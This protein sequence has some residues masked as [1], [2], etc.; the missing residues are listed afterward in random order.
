MAL[1]RE[2]MSKAT[3]LSDVY[4]LLDRYIAKISM[5]AF[6]IHGLY[7]FAQNTDTKSIFNLPIKTKLSFFA[8]YSITTFVSIQKS[9]SKH[10]INWFKL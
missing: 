6:D 4:Y 10:I 7:H 3:L 5:Y 2:I 9:L 1:I 8:F